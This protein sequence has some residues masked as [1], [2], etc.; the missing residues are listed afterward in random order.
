LYPLVPP[1]PVLEDFTVGPPP[2]RSG[3]TLAVAEDYRQLESSVERDGHALEG[4]VGLARLRVGGQRV[5]MGEDVVR[6]DHPGRLD[7]AARELEELL[8]LLLLGV[9]EDQ[10]E[11]V[12]DRRQ[13]LEGVALDDLG[14][15]L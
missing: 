9:E 5:G 7:L 12:V 3:P 13:R 6:D 4:R 11:D 15:V 14:P 8:V 10:V 1:L 2:F